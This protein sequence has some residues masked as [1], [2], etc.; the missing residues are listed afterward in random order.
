MSYQ[1]LA[2]SIVAQAVLD[3]HEKKA[4]DESVEEIV[5]FLNGDW[6]RILLANTPYDGEEILEVLE[7]RVH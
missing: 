6:C 2:Y 5:E 7:S 4:L 1:D 3:Y